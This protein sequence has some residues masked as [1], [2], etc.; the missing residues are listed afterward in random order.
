MSDEGEACPIPASRYGR[1]VLGHGS[2]GRL[3]AELLAEVF[4]A[5]YGEHGPDAREDA[6]TLTTEG[7]RIA[8]TTDSFVVHPRS[9]PGG[10]I[11]SLAVYGTVNDLAVAGARPE[12]ITAAFILEEGLAL[13]ELAAIVASMRR[14]C[15][16]AGV[17]LVAGDTKVVDRGK[18][19]GLFV[20][21]TGIGRI[22]AGR[23]LSA[24]RARPG[25]AVLV[26][27]TMG[28]HGVAILSVREGLRLEGAIASDAAPLT[29]LVE[30]VLAAAPETRCMRDP[31][32]GGLASAL[33]ELAVASNVSV[34]CEEA[35]VPVG[36]A[37]RGACELLG[38]DPLYVANEGKLIA[39]CA[40]E[41]AE[42]LLA[43]MRAHPLGANAA[44][45]G[46]VHADPHH[47]VQMKT[48][49]GG[50]RIVDWLSGEQLPRIC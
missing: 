20:T 43:A 4:L 8:V 30:A 42:L 33:H 17:R 39:I 16:R 18:G 41:H 10:D 7:A 34:L 31:T 38:L 11:G 2:G 46:E 32:R 44:R 9:F 6:A 26:S 14:A 50:R 45:I 3:G 13:D 35:R 49:F 36:D 47:F 24:T 22:P 37:V 19:D 15:E 48:G 12:W 1:V 28:D 23:A 29:G 5:G 21:T 27:G 40:P 25:D